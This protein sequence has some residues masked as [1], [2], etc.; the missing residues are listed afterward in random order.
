MVNDLVSCF[1]MNGCKTTEPVSS[2]GPRGCV[3]FSSCVTDSIE[4]NQI[5]RFSDVRRHPDR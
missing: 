3:L 4:A 2:D 1:Y 5:G